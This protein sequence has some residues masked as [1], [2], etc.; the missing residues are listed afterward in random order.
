MPTIDEKTSLAAERILRRPLSEEE[1]LEIY[2]IADVMGM[3][4]VQSFLYLLLVFKL[5]EDNMNGQFGEML[6]LEDRLNKKFDEMNDLSSKIDQT[7]KDSI[8]K[9]LGDGAREIGRDMG[10]HIADGAREA[11]SGSGDY[12][13]LRGQVW[14][15][16]CVSVLVTAA[17]WL[18]SANVF[19]AGE[20]SPLDT[21][22]RLDSG[23]IAFICGSTYAYMWAYDH[24]RQVKD[25]RY[26][27]AG[28]ALMAAALIMTAAYLLR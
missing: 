17:Y 2:R 18:G 19:H 20:G 12:H 1:Q 6:K 4:D 26:Y 28:L 5:H 16:F 10:G 7:L 14:I 25:S 15:V 13:F 9:I 22:M 23:W 3:R 11:L 27:M 24:W 8:E 21:L